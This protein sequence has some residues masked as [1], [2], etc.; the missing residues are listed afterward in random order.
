MADEIV[1]KISVPLPSKTSTEYVQGITASSPTAWGTGHGG[2]FW[3]GSPVCLLQN[4]ITWSNFVI[5][6]NKKFKFIN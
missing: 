6:D 2:K 5:S 1:F 3:H 4:K